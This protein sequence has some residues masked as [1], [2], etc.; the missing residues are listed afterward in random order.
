M[1]RDKRLTL[2][3]QSPA[4]P[5]NLQFPERF[6]AVNA[7]LYFGQVTPDSLE[8]G[9]TDGYDCDNAHRGETPGSQRSGVFR[10]I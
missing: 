9:D 3:R 4:C 2:V 7:A 8:T 10:S 6:A 1:F 5:G